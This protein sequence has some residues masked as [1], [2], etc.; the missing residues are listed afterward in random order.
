MKEKLIRQVEAY[1]PFNEQEAADKATL[2]SLLRRILLLRFPEVYKL[3]HTLQE[4]K[5]PFHR[6]AVHRTELYHPEAAV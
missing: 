4:P 5:L 3:H 2:L 6:N 1:I